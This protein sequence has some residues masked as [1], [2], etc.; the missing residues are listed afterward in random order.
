MSRF[1]ALSFKRYLI[2]AVYRETNAKALLT[3][4]GHQKRFLLSEAGIAPRLTR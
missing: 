3:T 1:F 2:R 4:C